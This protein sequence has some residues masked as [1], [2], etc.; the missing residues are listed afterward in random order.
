MAKII[1]I[2]A[3]NISLFALDDHGNIYRG[4]HAGGKWVTVAAPPVP[5]GEVK[6]K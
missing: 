3:N 4:P 2:A 6:P 1:Q 5:G